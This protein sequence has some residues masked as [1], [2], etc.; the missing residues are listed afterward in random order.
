MRN[1]HF[2]WV[3]IF[4]TLSGKLPTT[5][6]RSTTLSTR[7]AAVCDEHSSTINCRRQEAGSYQAHAVGPP[8]LASRSTARPVQAVSADTQ[9]AAWTGTVVHCRSLSTSHN[10]R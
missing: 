5:A 3:S 7:P 1:V 8:S 9:G 2:G 10:R 4:N 6:G